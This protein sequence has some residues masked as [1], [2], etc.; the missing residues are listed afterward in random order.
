MRKGRNRTE[1]DEEGKIPYRS[2][3]DEEGKIWDEQDEEGKI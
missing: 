3:Q 1:Q 2:E